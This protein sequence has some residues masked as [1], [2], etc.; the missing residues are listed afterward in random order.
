[1]DPSDPLENGPESVERCLERARQGS[2]E[3]LG[4]LL[5]MCRAYLLGVANRELDAQLRPKGGASDIVQEAFLEAQRIFPRF[6]GGT[7]P[8]LLAWLRSVLLHKLDDF[9]RRYR[10]ADKRR[11]GREIGLEDAVVGND[12]LADK[13]RSPSSA[14]SANE[15]AELVRQ[16]LER[17]PEHYRQVIVWRQWD[18]LSF[19]EIARRLDRSTDAAR[20]L[21]WR[22]VERLEE[23]LRAPP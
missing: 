19:E 6:E 13:G 15:Q 17:L 8:E 10:H 22:A 5:E 7:A 23:E 2:R 11:V 9:E 3:D 4:R 18:E 1:M 21:W 20:M 14:A 16:A 12:A